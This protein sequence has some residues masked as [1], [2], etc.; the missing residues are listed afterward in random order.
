MILESDLRKLVDEA[1]KEVAQFLTPLAE[2]SDTQA[3]RIIRRYTAVFEGN[4]VSWMCGALITAR[5]NSG[6]DAITKNLIVELRDSHPGMLRRFAKSCKA[7]PGVKDYRASYRHVERIR[8]SD[9]N[10]LGLENFCLV[11]ILENA[12]LAF[13]PYLTELGERLGCADFEYTKVHGLADIDH[14]RGL[15]AALLGEQTYDYDFVGDRM[16]ATCART[17]TLLRW[18]FK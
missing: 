5:S 6:K 13:I 14:A 7:E 8:Q 10:G 11:T 16:E 18:I 15:Y 12:S 9:V 2:L 4:F 3:K 1:R 17:I